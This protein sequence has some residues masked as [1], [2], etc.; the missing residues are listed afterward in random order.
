MST[1]T[2]TMLL[3][4]EFCVQVNLIVLS[5]K[6]VPHLDYDDASATLERC[7]NSGLF[8]L[9]EVMIPECLSKFTWTWRSAWDDQPTLTYPFTIA[10]RVKAL[11]ERINKL[12]FRQRAP[13]IAL[14]RN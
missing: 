14:S 8:P 13:F 2:S 9:K 3:S 12:R 10:K 6:S 11:N 4:V 1:V 7:P 5:A